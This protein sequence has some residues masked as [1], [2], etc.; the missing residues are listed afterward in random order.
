MKP[1]AM[2]GV[3]MIGSVAIAAPPAEGLPGCVTFF[4]TVVSHDSV[5][6]TLLIDVWPSDWTA[7]TQ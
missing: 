5:V 4:V 1:K 7:A 6:V 3:Q 2:T